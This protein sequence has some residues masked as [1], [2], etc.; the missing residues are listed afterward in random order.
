MLNEL[1]WEVL[2]II[3]SSSDRNSQDLLYGIRPP[4][5]QQLLAGGLWVVF[6]C[7]LRLLKDIRDSLR[8]LYFVFTCPIPPSY[9][10]PVIADLN[11]LYRIDIEGPSFFILAHTS[12]HWRIPNLKIRSFTTN[13]AVGSVRCDTMWPKIMR[14]YLLANSPHSAT[15][16]HTAV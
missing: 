5:D 8:G 3:V 7:N 6:L 13:L 15:S 9:V 12:F 4:L 10:T 1:V 11:R 16:S 2:G 14:R